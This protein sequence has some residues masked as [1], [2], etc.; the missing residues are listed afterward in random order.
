MNSTLAHAAAALIDA[1]SA[2]VIAFFVIKALLASARRDSD[3]ARL[4][5]ADGVILALG[6]S[7]AGALLKTIGA[8]TWRQIGIFAFV[9]AFRTGMKRVFAEER[10]MLRAGAS[11]NGKRAT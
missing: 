1:G 4:L 3:R 8:G 2:V 10:R 7:V 11:P 5:M 6:F 9:L